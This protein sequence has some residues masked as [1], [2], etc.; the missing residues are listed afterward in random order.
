MRLTSLYTR[1]LGSIPIG[2]T[3][4]GALNFITPLEFFKVQKDYLF[5]NGGWVILPILLSLVVSIIGFL[6]YL[7][8][9][10]VS[11]SLR[12][13]ICRQENHEAIMEEGKRRLLNLPFILG[14]L[15]LAMWLFFPGLMTTFFT[16]AT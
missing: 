2:A 11:E 14:F 12:A 7:I 10:P 5:S 9:R 15:N 3:V 4:V 16:L 13:L 1:N 8:Q 6:Q